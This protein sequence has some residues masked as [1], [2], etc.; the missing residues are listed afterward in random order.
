MKIFYTTVILAFLAFNTAFCWVNKSG[1]LALK[2]YS[3]PYNDKEVVLT[4]S[5]HS[6]LIDLVTGKCYSTKLDF[7]YGFEL[8]GTIING[9]KNRIGYLS[10][11]QIYIYNYLTMEK[12]SIIST[13]FDWNNSN[14]K[15]CFSKDGSLVYILNKDELRLVV[16]DAFSGEKKDEL[17][18]D[19]NP[20]LY[21][22]GYLNGDKEEFALIKNDSMEFWSIAAKSITRKIPFNSKAENVEFRNNGDN[23]TLVLNTN[24]FIILNSN[25]GAEIFN[26]ICPSTISNYEFSANMQFLICNSKYD[27][28]FLYDIKSDTLIKNSNIIENY[29]YINSDYTKVIGNEDIY[30][31]CNSDDMPTKSPAYFLYDLQ[32]LNKITSIPEGL[33]LRPMKI[34]SNDKNNRIAVVGMN[35]TLHYYTAILDENGDFIKYIHT[36]EM[37]STFTYN[38]DYLVS[39]K[40]G[41]LYFYN[42]EKDSLERVLETGRDYVGRVFFIN[43]STERIVTVNLDYI[44][45]YDFDNFSLLFTIDL[46]S[47]GN[48]LK[49][50]NCDIKGNIKF[51]V[52]SV[53]YS[54]D[55]YTGTSTPIELSNIPSN[56]TIEDISADGL[57]LLFSINNDSLLVYDVIS[58]KILIS[59]KIKEYSY[60]EH[61]FSKGFLGSYMLIWYSYRSNP[62]EGWT[63]IKAY[64]LEKK[65]EVGI[66]GYPAP[67]VSKDGLYYG[68]VDCPYHYTFNHIPKEV[69]VNDDF[70]LKNNSLI[71]PNPARDYI[72]INLEAIAAI[73]PTLKR[74]ADEGSD[75]QIFDML[76]VN[77][78]TSVC[79]AATSAS[80]GQRINVSALQPGM[81]FIKIGNRVEKFVKM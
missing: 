5:T 33:V 25:T 74:G 13:E 26:K 45:V 21:S 48:S 16:Y 72:V 27:P 2:S 44:D 50:I 51:L 57:H 42:I 53:F 23:I 79:F 30:F 69:S 36:Q 56:A 60:P 1:V 9:A 6:S 66:S 35:D 47:L 62:M 28:D 52:D 10:K 24:N 8:K 41:K 15:V 54:F 63:F 64:D 39:N 37:P 67:Y 17:I 32:K 34:F 73:N 49:L 78:S 38:S 43:K 12:I 19:S 11:G 59:Y 22:T 61:T 46:K 77:V 20:K 80:G 55:A 68:D 70:I 14:I 65:I 7:P 81:Y 18:I 29:L 58:Q 75:I 3:N 76:G 71:Y 31:S 40:Y 4:G